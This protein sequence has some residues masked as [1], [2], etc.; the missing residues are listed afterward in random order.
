MNEWM[1]A[2]ETNFSFVD[3]K[4]I[5]D[6]D[7]NNALFSTVR[8][9]FSSLLFFLFKKFLLYL[10]LLTLSHGIRVQPTESV[11]KREWC[12]E[13]T[14]QRMSDLHDHFA[15]ELI[16]IMMEYTWFF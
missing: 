7:K 3:E 11:Q 13:E 2:P 9:W 16:M 14:D 4:A 8:R 10:R 5:V 12:D 15:Y 1:N 6:A